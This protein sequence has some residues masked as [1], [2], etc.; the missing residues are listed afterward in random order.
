MIRRPGMRT[1]AGGLALLA[2]LAPATLWAQ[3]KTGTAVGQFL[4]I[5]PSARIIPSIAA[6]A[7][8]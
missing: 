2:L 4:L 5:E 6:L 1:V 7:A 8:E 3:T